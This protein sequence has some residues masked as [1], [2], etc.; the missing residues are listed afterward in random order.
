MKKMT[1]LSKGWQYRRK[2]SVEWMPAEVPGNVHSDLLRNGRIESPYFRDNERSLQWIDKS[3]WEYRIVLGLDPKQIS[4]RHQTLI[5]DGLDTYAR[6]WLNDVEVLSADNMYRRFMVDV[7]KYLRLGR[8]ELRVIFSSPTLKALEEQ[9]KYGIRLPAVND[10]SGIGGMGH[11]KVS[12]FIRKAP[13]HFGW[14]W[15]PRLVTMGIW[16]P[17]WLQVAPEGMIDDF[18]I[19][20]LEINPENARLEAQIVISGIDE[21]GYALRILQPK[22]E[23][24]WELNKLDPGRA[25]G[26][27]RIEL[28]IVDPDLW[29]PN[30][31]GKQTLTRF[32]A[33]LLKNNTIVDVREVNTGLRRVELVREPDTQGKTFYFRINGIPVFAKGANYIPN[34]IFLT[35]VKP[36]G[37]RRILQSAVRAN[38]NMLRVWGG[39]IYENDAFYDLCDQL[40]LMVWQDFMFACSMYPGTP[41][42][43]EN[44]RQE[45][46]DNVIRLRNHPCLVLWCGNNE[47]DTAWSPNK[48]IGGWGWKQRY[49]SRNR[50]KIWEAYDTLFH[51]LLPDIVTKF[52]GIRTYWPSSPLADWGETA[53]YATTSGD[54]HYWGVWHNDEPFEN[55]GKVKARFMSEYGFQALPQLSTIIKFTVPEDRRLDSAVMRSHQRCGFG[56]SKILQYMATYLPGTR[57]FEET[58]YASQF[59]QAY[60]IERAI[61]LHRMRKPYT[62]GSLFWQLNDCWPVASWSSLDYYGNWKGLHH[63][64]RNAFK[65]VKILAS[66]GTSDVGIWLT[67]DVQEALACELKMQWIDFEGDVLWEDQLHVDTCFEKTLPVYTFRM[68]ADNPAIYRKS[69]LTCRLKHGGRNLDRK[70]IWFYIPK[71]LVLPHADMT[72]RFYENNRQITI[73]VTSPVA[74]MGVALD[75]GKLDVPL[76][77]NYFDLLPGDTKRVKILTPEISLDKARQSLTLFCVNNLDGVSKSSF[78]LSIWSA[79]RRAVFKLLHLHY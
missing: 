42:F 53:S 23:K 75:F 5:F 37:Y 69:L 7:S 38:M 32:K 45:A 20:Q 17:V 6:V 64:V 30:G 28:E 50:K 25:N 24:I 8:N 78:G 29:Y 67:S 21:P 11:N 72:C 2:G 14:D 58:I 55:Y 66:M 26:V 27:N 10:Q 57:S 54:M 3:D 68:K 15:G 16:R 43:I 52:D 4:V 77:D 73:D 63:R 31:Y 1:E 18:Y 40:G 79:A 39:G 47:I 46:I 60:G 71:R 74:V 59:L 33:E 62:M 22:K 76:S 49:T 56:N 19:K 41:G 70:I 13:Y 36:A 61:D 44:V 34:D 48:K 35:E 51:Q 65:P 12:P 9:K